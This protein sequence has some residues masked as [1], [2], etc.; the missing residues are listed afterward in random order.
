M[1]PYTRA[2]DALL[3][4]FGQTPRQKARDFREARSMGE[5][6]PTE[7]LDHLEALLPDVKALFEV[8]LLDALPANAR[9]AALQH[10]GARAMAIAADAVVLEN[11]AAQACDRVSA[12]VNSMSLM[13]RD[14]ESPSACPAPLSPAPAVAAVGRAPPR[15]SLCQNH[16]RWGRE[17]YK[18]LAPA[19]C[20]MRSV[21]KPRPTPSPSAASGNGKAGG[22]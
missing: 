7:F 5:K 15:D 1:A 19:S 8:A 4:H 22:H 10:S 2:R 9:V 12:S 18:C 3:R 20:K 11:R 13:D 6:L 14:L 21:L 17:T 16:R